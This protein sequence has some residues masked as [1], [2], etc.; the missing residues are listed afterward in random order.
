MDIPG[1]F[2]PIIIACAVVPTFVSGC[3]RFKGWQSVRSEQ[4]TVLIVISKVEQAGTVVTV[5]GTLRLL[6]EADYVYDALYKEKW[7]NN[8]PPLAS[9]VGGKM[10]IEWLDSIGSKAPQQPGTYRFRL[11]A[12]TAVLPVRRSLKSFIPSR[13]PA[14]RYALFR[15]LKPEQGSRW[16]ATIRE[17]CIPIDPYGHKETFDNS[18]LK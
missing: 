3:A 15:V 5:D 10:A 1:R 11:K 4:H 6:R 7:A 8:Q 13:S 18:L 14:R 9:G 12:D 16:L 2:L 17:L